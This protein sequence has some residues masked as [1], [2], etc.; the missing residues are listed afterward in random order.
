MCENRRNRKFHFIIVYYGSGSGDAG[1]RP[2]SE[3]D[4]CNQQQQ[5]QQPSSLSSK[6]KSI[7]CACVHD[8]ESLHSAGAINTSNHFTDG[9][10]SPQSA[11]AMENAFVRTNEANCTG[12][13]AMLVLVE[14]IV[15]ATG[16]TSVKCRMWRDRETHGHCNA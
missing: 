3:R 6:N 13:G 11:S 5:R 7:F 14:H 9:L 15:V 12:L 4:N 16:R 10:A 2:R 1:V 8:G